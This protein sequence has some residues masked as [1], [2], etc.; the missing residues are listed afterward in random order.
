MSEVCIHLADNNMIAY[1]NSFVFLMYICFVLK[2]KT[3]EGFDI[4]V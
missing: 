4:F 1:D 3:E 2:K